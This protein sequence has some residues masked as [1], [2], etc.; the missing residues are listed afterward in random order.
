MRA[1]KWKANFNAN[2]NI[3]TQIETAQLMS[4]AVKKYDCQFPSI[5]S[6]FPL[7]GQI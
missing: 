4:A 7:T 3:H 1:D 5:S 2:L 6:L